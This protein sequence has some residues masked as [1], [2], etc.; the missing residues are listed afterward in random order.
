MEPTTAINYSVELGKRFH[1]RYSQTFADVN[2]KVTKAYSQDDY[3]DV[4]VSGLVMPESGGFTEVVGTP[5]AFPLANPAVMG[6]KLVRQE[7][8]TYILRVIIPWSDVE[9]T[10]NDPKYFEKYFDKLVKEVY[11]SVESRYGV[12]GVGVEFGN[13]F[14]DYVQPS[15][16]VFLDNGSGESLEMRFIGNFAREKK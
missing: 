6:T 4:P 7:A 2:A 9:A 11:S 5:E 12:P 3:F 13:S 1:A 15:G 14:I 16:Q 10:H 8:L